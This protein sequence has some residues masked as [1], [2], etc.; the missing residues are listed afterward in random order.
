MKKTHYSLLFLIFYIF[1]IISTLLSTILNNK[2]SDPN[3]PVTDFRNKQT[4]SESLAKALQT[5]QAHF[6]YSYYQFF[7]ISTTWHEAKSNCEN[8]GMHLVTISSY[9]ENFFLYNLIANSGIW[10]GMSDE[11][12]EGD[13]QWITGEPILFTNWNEGQPDNWGEGEDFAVMEGEE[14]WNDVGTQEGDIPEAPYVC[15]SPQDL[16]NQESAMENFQYSLYQIF[17]TPVT[18]HQA[19]IRCEDL[20]MHLVT[21]NSV[22]ENNFVTSLVP[23]STIWLGF[24]DENVEGNWEWVTSEPV[25]FTNW[26][27]TEPNDSAGGEDYAE[28]FGSN[29]NDNGAPADPDLKLLYVC[30]SSDMDQDEIPDNI[31]IQIGLD[32]TKNDSF[33]DLDGDNM[34]NIWE[35][36]MGLNIS[37]NDAEKDAD[38]DGLVNL[39]EF[40]YGTSPISNDTDGDDM[41]DFWEVRMDLNP[42]KID[43]NKDK[44]NDWIP[45]GIEYISGTN[46]ND[47]WNVPIFSSELPFIVIS[48]PIII[49]PILA[50]SSVSIGL[51]IALIMQNSKKRKLIFETKAPDFETSCI[52][53]KEK[54]FDYEEYKSALDLNVTTAEEFRFVLELE[55]KIKKIIENDI[56]GN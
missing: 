53:K 36:Q 48:F 54:F 44:D 32:P 19:K 7:P 21:I 37:L 45:N 47:F 25:V 30:E 20:T 42:L 9:E 49:L 18:W 31:E 6:N 2:N 34:P 28:M 4:N 46:A 22:Y 33:L 27:S 5:A 41:D 10:L 16:M 11:A 56:L 23:Y 13:W 50:L 43:K 52:I 8:L 26:E 39:E 3:R 51:I 17:Y 12:N 38:Q 15:E 40:L 55:E 1:I 35:Y 14:L 29:W 24:T